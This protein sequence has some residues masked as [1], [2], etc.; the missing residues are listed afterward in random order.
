MYKPLLLFITIAVIFYGC[1]KKSPPAQPVQTNPVPSVPVDISLF[2]GD[3][4]NFSIQSIGGWKYFLGGINGIIVYRKSQE[5]FVAIERTSSQLPNNAAAKVKVQNDNFSLLD[6]IS[7]SKWQIIDGV[8]SLGPAVWP[9]RL[10]GTT[11]DGNVLRIK[12]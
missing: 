10:Y 4:L 3:P 1:K 12:N 11:F 6:S 8:V 2:P 5:E 9:L 7:G